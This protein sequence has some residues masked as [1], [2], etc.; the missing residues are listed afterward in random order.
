MTVAEAGGF[1]CKV[2]RRVAKYMGHDDGPGGGGNRFRMRGIAG[3]VRT[4][5]PSA[6]MTKPRSGRR[7][8]ATL[9]GSA[10]VMPLAWSHQGRDSAR[11]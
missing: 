11:T 6:T 2:D 5:R 9:G 7:R 8:G 1:R 10:N 4:A 3:V